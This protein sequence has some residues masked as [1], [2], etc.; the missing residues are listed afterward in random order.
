MKLLQLNLWFGKLLN[1]ALNYI[2]K[3]QPDILCLQEVYS[4]ETP[5][6]QPDK[7][8]D[9]LEQIKSVTGYENCFF[10][11]T[12]TG[13]YFGV[14]TSFGNAIISRYPLS[15]AKYLFVNAEYNENANNENIEVNAR[16]LQT[17]W[18]SIE[19][20][21]F[22]LANYHGYFV[23]S[24]EGDDVTVEKMKIVKSRV[25]ELPKPIIFSG[26]FNVADYSKAMRVFDGFLRD[27]TSENKIKSTLSQFGKVKDVACDHILISDG[28][29]VTSFRVAEDLVSDHKP[30]IM[31]FNL[32]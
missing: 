7:M 17:C 5:I 13:E 30:L 9:S 21:S 8:F 29:E 6:L 31:E 10:S 1:P 15:D 16:V 18:V 19:G 4:S 22:S 11:P 23:P 27:L 12:Y 24:P 2:Q 20:K 28:I 14:K 25:D 32:L 26:D 3:E